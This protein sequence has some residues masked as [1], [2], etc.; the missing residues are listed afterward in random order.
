M[1]SLLDYLESAP[2]ESITMMRATQII[3]IYVR[4]NPTELWACMRSQGKRTAS[5]RPAGALQLLQAGL[6]VTGNVARRMW[7]VLK[8]LVV[9]L[10]GRG[11]V[12]EVFDEFGDGKFVQTG[13][14]E[15]L[16]TDE[17]TSQS[18]FVL[19]SSCQDL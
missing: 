15:A 9:K 13:T 4:S 6:Q 7:D 10:L 11:D 5:L 14:S 3:E 1:M 12:R 17:Q 8:P 18:T 19:L 16:S 2:N